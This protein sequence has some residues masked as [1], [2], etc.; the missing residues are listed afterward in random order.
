[1]IRRMRGSRL[2][3]HFRV[4]DIIGWRDNGFGSWPVSRNNGIKTTPNFE[5]K[6]TLC[7]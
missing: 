4:D 3:S 6:I 7:D 5:K 1:M 2:N